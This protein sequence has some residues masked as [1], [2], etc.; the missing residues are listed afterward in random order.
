MVNCAGNAFRSLGIEQENRV[1]LA[2]PDSAEFIA[3]FFGAA[4]MSPFR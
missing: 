2:A 1:L 4:K 3:G